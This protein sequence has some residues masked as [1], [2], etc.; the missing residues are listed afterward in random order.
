MNDKRLLDAF[1]KELQEASIKY[2]ELKTQN[3]QSTERT[4]PSNLCF[5][6]AAGNA[7]DNQRVN[8]I[9][10]GTAQITGVSAEANQLALSG[11][12]PPNCQ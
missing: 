6:C 5:I 2:N 3:P 12:T 7:V 9:A 8:N 1:K 10:V 4:G 11:C